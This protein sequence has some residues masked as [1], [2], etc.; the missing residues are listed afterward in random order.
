M[1]FTLIIRKE[2]TMSEE[3]GTTEGK[4]I[5]KTGWGSSPIVTLGNLSGQSELE[6]RSTSYFLKE[7]HHNNTEKRTLN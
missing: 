4:K 1:R 6:V 7:V 3:K 5:T 2:K